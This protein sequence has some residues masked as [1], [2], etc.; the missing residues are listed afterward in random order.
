MGQHSC[1]LWKQNSYLKVMLFG[2]KW[3]SE[4]L[5]IFCIRR[6][7]FNRVSE[8]NVNDAECILYI[9]LIYT[10]YLPL[11]KKMDS[12]KHINDLTGKSYDRNEHDTHQLLCWMECKVADWGRIT[13]GVGLGLGRG[14]SGGEAVHSLHSPSPRTFTPSPQYPQLCTLLVTHTLLIFWT[15]ITVHVELL[16]NCKKKKIELLSTFKH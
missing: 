9:E 10:L 5:L 4:P 15:H 8:I 1:C 14:V 12:C 11:A 13:S 7:A 16:L 6:L 2:L 3:C